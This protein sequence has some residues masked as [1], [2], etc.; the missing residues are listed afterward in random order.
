MRAKRK[1][2]A[3]LKLVPYRGYPTASGRVAGLC[4]PETRPVGAMRIPVGAAR[5]G[6]P[7]TLRTPTRERI[8]AKMATSQ[9]SYHQ[10]KLLLIISEYVESRPKPVCSGPIARIRLDK[11]CASCYVGPAADTGRLWHGETVPI[12]G[13]YLDALVGTL[14]RMSSVYGAFVARRPELAVPG[15]GG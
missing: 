2:P 7:A 10:P 9:Q 5:K 1:L 3:V 11:G 12:G 13:D 6:N 15:L 8:C 14:D 4:A